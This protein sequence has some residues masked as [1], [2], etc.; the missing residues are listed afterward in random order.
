M[1]FMTEE[2]NQLIAKKEKIRAELNEFVK[3]HRK[4]LRAEVHSDNKVYTEEQER[5]QQAFYDVLSECSKYLQDIASYS[6]F[7]VSIID[8]LAELISYYEGMQH[9]TDTV[10]NIKKDN[11]FGKEIEYKERL[12]FI[13]PY[14]VSKKYMVDKGLVL[15]RE[16]LALEDETQ[17]PKEII[18]YYSTGDGLFSKI[19]FS[20]FPYVQ[21]YID[22]I[23]D[24]KIKY[25]KEVS[26][27]ALRAMAKQFL[28]NRMPTIMLY[29]ATKF[30]K[31]PLSTISPSQIETGLE[32]ISPKL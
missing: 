31:G 3:A 22:S 12:T 19:D 20:R 30:Q 1:D 17:M 4:E 18:F 2:Y 32:D 29:Q 21:D 23:I 15:S 7:D 11:R 10:T 24:Y 13:T 27:E 28:D 5:L 25:G 14:Y 8:I 6:K 9:I 16:K 26:N